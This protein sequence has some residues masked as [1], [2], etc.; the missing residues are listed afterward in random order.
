LQGGSG[1]DTAEVNGG[2]GAETFTATANGTRV[3][4]DRIDPAPFSIDNGATP[5]SRH[6]RP[7]RAGAASW[8]SWL[9]LLLASRR[10]VIM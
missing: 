8:T 5:G 7:P 1:I 6:A 2:N 4:F 3:R 9:R 10:L